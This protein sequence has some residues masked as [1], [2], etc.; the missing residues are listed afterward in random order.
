MSIVPGVRPVGD[1]AVLV[2]LPG[3]ATVRKLAAQLPAAMA[4]LEDGGA[5]HGT[6]RVTRGR[7]RQPPGDLRARV[8]ALLAGP[9]PAAVPEHVE[10][11]VVYDGPDLADTAEALGM[12]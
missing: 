8:A 9:S 11:E 2:E 10:L 12:S 5:G 1:R 7:G 4:G 3:N 6:V